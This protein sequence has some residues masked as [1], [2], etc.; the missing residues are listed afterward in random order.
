MIKDVKDLTLRNHIEGRVKQRITNL[1]NLRMWKT[2]QVEE[3]G[4]EMQ[5]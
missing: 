4:G 1:P 5:I 3:R 2:E